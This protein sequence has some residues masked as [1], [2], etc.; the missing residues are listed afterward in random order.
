MSRAEVRKILLLWLAWLLILWTYQAAVT[1]R[2]SVQ[3]PDRV[4]AWVVPNTD[5]SLKQPYLSESF[6]NAQVAWDSEFYLSIALSGYDDPQV[7]AV[8]PPALP[9]QTLSLNY[10]FFP[11]YPYLMRF[12][13]Q[14]FSLL[15]LNPIAAATSA[16]L[17]ISS[18]GTLAGMIALYDLLSELGAA[19]ALRSVFY[20]ITFPTSFFLGQVYTEGLFIGLSF[21][22]LALLKRRQWTQASL[23]AAIATLTRPVGVMLLLPLLWSW[24][25]EKPRR[26]SRRLI[27]FT[28]LLPLLV[29]LLWRLSPLGSAFQIVQTNHFRCELLNLQ[30]ACLAWWSGVLALFGDNPAAVV[31]YGIEL[32]AIGLGVLSC[33][34][35]LKRYPE[36]SIYGLTILLISTTCG[37]AWSLSRYLLAV[38]SLFILLSQLGQSALFDRAWS[39]FSILLLAMLTTLF[40][41]DLW[42]G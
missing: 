28:L 3:K 19:T 29:H 42:A 33:L 25:Q 30:A 26:S 39:L 6:M 15:G 20:L 40:S 23:L 18:L 17:L 34:F 7:R 35:T 22:C 10:A 11:V 14:P 9:S 36:I 31:H 8:S 41:F 24:M 12:V 2:Y 13:A 37:T 1:A 5:G 21:S 27:E 38:P 4:L 16:G 32:S